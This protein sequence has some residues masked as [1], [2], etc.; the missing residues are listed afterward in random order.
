MLE[1]G[2]FHNGNTDLPLKRTAT[3][4]VLPTGD[5]ADMH[6]SNQRVVQSQVRQGVLAEKLGL[7]YFW[8]TEHHF[9]P[10]GAEFSP[11]PLIVES[12]VAAQTGRIRLGQFANIITW[13]HPIR[14]AEQAAMLDVISHGRLE[15]GFGRGYQPRENETF[16]RNYGS[17]IQDQERN[18]SSFEEAYE[19]VLKAWT[20]PSFSHRGE[21]FSIPPTYTKWHH[22]QTMELFG[23]PEYGRPL[24]RVIKVGKP[25]LYSAGNP[26]VASTSIL[27]EISVFPQ[28]LQKPHPPLWMPLTS[29]RSIR[30]AAAQGVNGGFVAEP[31]WRLK[32]N[33]EQYYDE[34]EKRGWPDRL[35]RGRFKYGWDAEQHRGISITKVCHIMRDPRDRQALERLALG[36]ELGW[37]YYGGFGFAPLLGNPGED[38]PADMRVSLD[39]L[40]ERGAALV[41]TPEDV[42]EQILKIKVEVGFEDFC[43]V[44][45]LEKGG[46]SA[47]EIEEQMH[48]FAE[49]VVPILRRECGGP[50]RQQ[51]QAAAAPDGGG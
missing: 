11:N 31:I 51:G 20:E 24:E 22:A 32:I 42:A 28:P 14:F 19:I 41:G 4:M 13:W 36:V 1:V 23:Q 46:Y 38:L 10:E 30:W 2:M 25:D 26:V 15:C 3:G 43:F 44:A 27:K 29:E 34:A 45:H 8:M 5:L 21:N 47:E 12:A 39:L 35:N 50:A 40:R 49:E 48:L 33:V 37:C 18:R 16:G 7:D 17:T 6:A 9:Q